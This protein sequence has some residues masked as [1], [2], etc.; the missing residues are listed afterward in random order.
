MREIERTIP[1]RIFTHVE[2]VSMAR[3]SSTARRGNNEQSRIMPSA[4]RRAYRLAHGAAVGNV[5]NGASAF[6]RDTV[7]CAP[8]GKNP[9]AHATVQNLLHIVFSTK[10]RLKLIPKEKQARTWAYLAGICHQQKIFVHEIG[11]MDDHL[12]MLIQLPPTIALADAVQEIKGSSSKWMGK[13]FAWQ[14]GYGAFSV[15]KSTLDQVARY[16]RNQE[17]HHRRRN[18]EQEFIAL[19]E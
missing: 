5:Y 10:D 16:I 1:A 7:Q 18:Y 11:G 15:C 14:R 17:A 8:G 6:R 4:F 13:R 19:L 2:T 12:H 9:L 3:H